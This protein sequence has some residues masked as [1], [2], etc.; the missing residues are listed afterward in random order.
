MT[1]QKTYQL[2][3]DLN[4]S[5][6]YDAVYS[7]DSDSTSNYA[8]YSTDSALSSYYAV[9]STFSINNETDKYRLSVGS[10]NGNTGYDS[11]SGSNNKPFSTRDRDNDGWSSYDCAE[12]HQGAWWFYEY[13]HCRKY[14]S[15]SYCRHY[16]TNYSY[17]CALFPDGSDN[18][19]FC[20]NSHLNGDYDG[21]TRGTNIYW[22]T[23]SDSDTL[24]SYGCSLQYTD[25]KIRPV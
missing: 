13:Y 6:S 1:N 23:H 10:Y 7:T 2:R 8:A 12:R 11:L 14:N 4:D 19:A 5:S 17:Y 16:C 15:A 3:I 25:M 9:Y 18:C 24:N 21:S 20:A 22:Y